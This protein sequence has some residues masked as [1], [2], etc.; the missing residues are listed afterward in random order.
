MVIV[1][2]RARGHAG[3]EVTPE[4]YGV[5]YSDDR[6]P[7]LEQTEWI[8]KGTD[9]KLYVVPSEPGGWMRRSEYEGQIEKLKAL[10]QKKARSICWTVYGDV[11]RVTMEGAN[12]EQR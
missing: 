5:Y 4:L 8:I 6:H 9:G 11:G 1:T 10:S 2:A 3:L 12:L 7:Q